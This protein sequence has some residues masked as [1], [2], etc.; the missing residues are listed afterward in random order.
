MFRRFFIVLPSIALCCFS[1]SVAALGDEPSITGDFPFEDVA[2]IYSGP[3]TR[4]D[5]DDLLVVHFNGGI[6]FGNMKGSTS[7]G[8]YKLAL[9]SFDGGR[10]QRI[11]LSREIMMKYSAVVMDDGKPRE[12]VSGTPWCF[13][14]FDRDGIYS[15]IT[16]TVNEMSERDFSKPKDGRE[17]FWGKSIKTPDI[18]IDQMIACDI[19]DDSCDEI[20]ALQF[21]DNP[22]SCCKYHVGIYRVVD[23]SLIEIWRG[24]YSKQGND[25]FFRPNQFI[26]KCRIDGIAGVVPVMNGPQGGVEPSSYISIARTQTGAYEIIRPFP[27]PY[28]GIELPA[29]G[30]FENASEQEK[31]HL[32]KMFELRRSK[33]FGPMGG[34]IFNDGNRVMHYGNFLDM[35]N[36]DPHEKSFPHAFSVLEDGQW[37]HLKKNDPSIRGLLCRFTIEAG[38]SGW[39]FINDGKYSFY[40]KLP[41]SD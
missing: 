15:I 40:D 11:W 12:V 13:G 20:V 10:F 35:R 41:V 6:V 26:S 2:E 22:D 29:K 34:V 36:P 14:D 18:W 4:P 16:C 5:R 8:T 38:K 23:D 7:S 39:L 17:A 9:Y 30:V 24:L 28:G 33:D 19:D 37:R 25:G 21:P 3:F 27:K 31:E 32:R 1:F